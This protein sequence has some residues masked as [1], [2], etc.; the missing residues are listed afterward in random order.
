MPS[1]QAPVPIENEPRHR[2]QFE[3]DVVRLFDVF[4]PP[5]DASLPHTHSHDTL[6]VELSNDAIWTE[7]EIGERRESTSKIGRVTSNTDYGEQPRSHRV[8]NAGKTPFHEICLELMSPPGSSKGK[9]LDG[10]LSRFSKVLDNEYAVAYLI[11]LPPGESTGK[12][13]Y[14]R[15]ALFIRLPDGG[16]EWI[17]EGSER[18][19]RNPDDAHT[20][21]TVVAIVL[22]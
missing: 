19:L 5:G 11:R 20:E 17:E 7:S 21:A 12:H 8:G 15:P 4:L 6:T 14:R 18:E 1:A 10:D 13:L 9:L 3:N 2:L 22:R 16:F